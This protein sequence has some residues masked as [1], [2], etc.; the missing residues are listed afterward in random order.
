MAKKKAIAT[1]GGK[2]QAAVPTRG[3]TPANKPVA[4][5]SADHIG[6]TAGEV[7]HLLADGG[8]LTPATLKKRVDAPGD[9]VMAA[10]GWL[11]REGKLSFSSNGRTTKVSLT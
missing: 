11:A 9:V 5:L 3:A 2:R 6:A 7:W 1:T 4:A 10:V 8:P